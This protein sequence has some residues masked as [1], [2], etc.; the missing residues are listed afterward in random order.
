MLLLLQE[1]LPPRPC[2]ILQLQ[3]RGPCLLSL[4]LCGLKLAKNMMKET[5][6]MMTALTPRW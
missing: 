4:S 2:L 5:R 3:E 6:K 1:G